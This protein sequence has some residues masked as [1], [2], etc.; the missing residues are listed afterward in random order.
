M[1]V[2]ME[3]EFRVFRLVALGSWLVSNLRVMICIKIRSQQ[4]C[5]N[6]E[7]AIIGLTLPAKGAIL[8]NSSRSVSHILVCGIGAAQLRRAPTLIKFLIKFIYFLI[9]NMLIVINI[10]N[11]TTTSCI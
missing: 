5:C 11:S 8:R 1:R 6:L 3:T 4:L 7:K 2:F 9:I 10:A